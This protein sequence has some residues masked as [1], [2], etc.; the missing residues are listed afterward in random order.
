MIVLCSPS[1]ELFQSV[2][3]KKHLMDLVGNQLQATKFSFSSPQAC[4]PADASGSMFGLKSSRQVT[5]FGGL[6]GATVALQG[7]AARCRVI[8]SWHVLCLVFGAKGTKRIVSMKPC[9]E[10]GG[11]VGWG[12]E[13]LSPPPSSGFWAAL[14]LSTLL[15][16]ESEV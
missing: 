9:E 11:D 3:S 13:G 15:F 12:L 10:G 8:R 16:S 6:R 2:A 14:C 5:C 1:V 4:T 7:A